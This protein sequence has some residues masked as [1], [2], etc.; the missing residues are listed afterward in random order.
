MTFVELIEHNFSS[1]ANLLDFIHCGTNENNS[2]LEYLLMSQ[3]QFATAT[4][5]FSSLA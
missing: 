1:L 3:S 4:L 2:P 5:P